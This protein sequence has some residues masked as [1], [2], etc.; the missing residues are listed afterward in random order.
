MININEYSE[1]YDFVIGFKS[2]EKRN[3]MTDQDKKHIRIMA[4]LQIAKNGSIEQIMNSE[5]TE[6][7]IYD[8]EDQMAYYCIKLIR[9]KEGKKYADC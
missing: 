9:R 3:I 7:F 1:K 6:K 8:K 2:K 5:F 4:I